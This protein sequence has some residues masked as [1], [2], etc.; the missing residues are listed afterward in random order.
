MIT[1]LKPALDRLYL[2]YELGRPVDDPVQFISR[3]EDSGDREIVGFLAAG[4]AFGRVASVMQS[5]ERVLA[6]MGRSPATFV[7]EFD[8]RRD[9]RAMD[10]L[11]HRW[12]RGADFVALMIVLRHVLRDAGSLEQFFAQGLA[13]HAADVT[14]ALESFAVRAGRMDVRSA[15]GGPDVRQGVRYFFPKPSSGSAC[16]RLNLFLR[17]MVRRDAIDPGG[18]SAVRPSQLVIPLDTHVIRVG[19][20]LGLTRYASPG[21]RMAADITAS[22]RRIDPDDPVK[23]DFALC[24]LGMSGACRFNQPRR[25]SSCPLDGVCRPAPRRRRAS[26]APSARE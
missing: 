20:C 17:W 5:V 12:T 21:W 15:Y 23:Y 3:Y 1:T 7:R 25:V 9:A 14:E 19:R 11:V 2:E 24:H 4:L 6:V 18:W 8:P 10:G 26:R 22:L 13:T 16:K